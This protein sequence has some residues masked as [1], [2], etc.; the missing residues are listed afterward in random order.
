[1]TLRRVGTLVLLFFLAASALGSEKGASLD[2]LKAKAESASNKDKPRL[3]LEIAQRQLTEADQQ[4]TLGDVDRGLA[5]VHD[6][7][8]YAER[9]AGAAL[10]SGKHQKQTE[11]AIREMANKMEA[12]VRSL[13]ID[14][15]PPVQAAVDRLQKIRDSLLT[16]MFKKD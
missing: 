4:Y 3:F 5:A 16:G 7:T 1:M 11:I 2:E 15:R 12:I 10:D 8:L 6:V 13:A 14:D 9:A